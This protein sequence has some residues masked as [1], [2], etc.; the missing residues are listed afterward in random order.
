MTSIGVNSEQLVCNVAEQLRSGIKLIQWPLRVEELGEEEELPPLI[1][2]LLSALWGKICLQA[3]SLSP[4]SSHS[5]SQSNQPMGW[6]ITDWEEG[7]KEKNLKKGEEEKKKGKKGKGEKKKK[8][9][10]NLKK[11]KKK[12]KRDFPAHAVHFL[13]VRF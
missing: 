3:L 10:K 5:M 13:M 1:A 6:G 9:K 7:G 8:N 12:R 2:K 4:P 11:K